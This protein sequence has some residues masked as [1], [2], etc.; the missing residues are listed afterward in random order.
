MELHIDKDFQRILGYSYGILRNT[1]QRSDLTPNVNKLNYIK[2]FLNIVDNKTE[3][4][5]LSE[6][7]VKS[8]VGGS[9]SLASGA[10][11]SFYKTSYVFP[12]HKKDSKALP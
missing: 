2:I 9:A 3:E 6:L 8:S 5:Y 11:P 1:I 12:L 7:F 4:N 10:V